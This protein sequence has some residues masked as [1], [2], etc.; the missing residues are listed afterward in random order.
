MEMANGLHVFILDEQNVNADLIVLENILSSRTR[1][2]Q[3]IWLIDI[4]ALNDISVATEKMSDL[5]LKFND[6]IFFFKYDGPTSYSII[7]DIWE[8]YKIHPSLD[9]IIMEYGNW[10]ESGQ[11]SSSNVAKWNRRK[12][13]LV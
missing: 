11:L 12:D 6:D 4:T 2:S 8:V 9:L 7:I 13:L 3:E 1:L 5:P 10:T